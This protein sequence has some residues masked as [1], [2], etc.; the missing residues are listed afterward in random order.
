MS[1][2]RILGVILGLLLSIGALLFAFLCISIYSYD[3]G[4]A[5]RQAGMIFSFLPFFVTFAFVVFCFYSDSTPFLKALISGVLAEL[6]VC[7]VVIG[8]AFML[9]WRGSHTPQARAE[10]S[11]V[12]TWQRIH[13]NQQPA[14]NLFFMHFY[15]DGTVA[16][17]PAPGEAGT[18]NGVSHE[19]YHF[20]REG[21]LLVMETYIGNRVSNQLMNVEIKSNAM[22]MVDAKTNRL[23]YHRVAGALQ[24]GH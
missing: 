16:T 23:T 22:T 9:Q 8:Y 20:E 19:D 12:G 21:R 2:L 7:V 15:A 24:P 6:C 13:V 4:I 17:W 18:T 5:H 14:T 10:R 3:S 11:I 1:A